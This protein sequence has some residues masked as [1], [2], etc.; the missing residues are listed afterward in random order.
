M[1]KL[2][3]VKAKMYSML[4]ND[5]INKVYIDKVIEGML[6]ELG[7]GAFDIL[8]DSLRNK[9]A[10]KEMNMFLLNK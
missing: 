4:K 8:E 10:L 7:V 2:E 6:K 1:S 9:R 5:G 3:Q